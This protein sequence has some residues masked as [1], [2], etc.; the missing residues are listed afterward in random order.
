MHLFSLP[1]ATYPTPHPWVV[2]L[3]SQNK[4][5]FLST[6]NVWEWPLAAS[7][8]LCSSPNAHHY[9][10]WNDI[11]AAFLSIISPSV[12]ASYSNPLKPACRARLDTC[13]LI[14]A[15]LAFCRKNTAGRGKNPECLFC[16]K[17]LCE[18][19]FFFCQQYLG[20]LGSIFI[21]SARRLLFC[22]KNRSRSICLH[23]SG[24]GN[25]FFS[26]KE[27]ENAPVTLGLRCYIRG[28]E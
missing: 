28:E 27:E 1:T 8:A 5:N 13:A 10:S 7:E 24:S 18:A 6:T 22:G 11:Q 3:A 17:L 4:R 15:K 23:V 19:I 21:C 2:G 25:T 9:Y 14:M 12:R 16:E 20:T 26:M